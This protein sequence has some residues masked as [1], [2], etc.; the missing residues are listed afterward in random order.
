M[1]DLQDFTAAFIECLYFADTGEPDQPA[2]DA[3]ISPET[4]LDIEADCRSFWRRFGC[5]VDAADCDRGNG[6]W[7]KAS[8]AGHDF[9][10]TRNGHGAGFW[11]GD[12]SKPY[13]DM[14]TD[15]AEAY[16]PFDIGQGEDGL[17]YAI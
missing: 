11:D 16:G 12:W 15:G 1:T 6:E 5:Y 17:I 3:N 7:S 4:M 9:Y 10:L 2:N 14:L 8:Q 13:A